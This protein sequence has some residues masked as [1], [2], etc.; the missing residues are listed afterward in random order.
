LV[1]SF[2]VG[3]TTEVL[4][5]VLDGAA[6]LANLNGQTVSVA[7]NQGVGYILAYDNGNA[8]LYAVTDRADGGGEANG[9]TTL[10]ATE[11]A[12][13][14]T[15]SGAAVGSITAPNLPMGG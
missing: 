15:I 8:Y 12:L 10:Q 2:D 9:D 11:I 7:A 13:I 14:G 3:G 4:A 6:L 5:G 1:F